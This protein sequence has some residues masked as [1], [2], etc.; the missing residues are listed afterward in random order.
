[1]RYCRNLGCLDGHSIRQSGNGRTGC[2]DV[3]TMSR[4]FSALIHRSGLWRKPF[5][6]NG[7]RRQRPMIQGRSLWVVLLL[8]LL[9]S[10]CL[11]IGLAQATAPRSPN[12]APIAQLQPS[13]PETTPASQPAIGTVD[14]IPDRY[15]P[16]KNLYLKNCATC[17]IGIPP[18]V[19][20]TETW[21]QLLQDSEHYGTTLAPLTGPNLVQVWEYIRTYSRPP[22]A[23]EP[24]PYRVYQ[25]RFFKS[26]HPRVTLPVKVGLGNCI[27]CHPGTG[28]YD[29][30]SLSAEWQNAP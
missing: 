17:H 4:R 21:R 10:V 9:W 25:S 30:R 26:L 12:P 19:M 14:V 28:N 22:A 13:P 16:G 15:Q 8:L 7:S 1:M 5:Q 3:C 24:V 20:P 18:E 27:S 29:F 2:F 23:D 11:G 6:R